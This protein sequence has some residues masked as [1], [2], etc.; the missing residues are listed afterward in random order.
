MQENE[1]TEAVKISII[2]LHSFYFLISLIRKTYEF[3][4]LIESVVK[5]SKRLLLGAPR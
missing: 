4:A 1:S 2:Y 3:F 5:L